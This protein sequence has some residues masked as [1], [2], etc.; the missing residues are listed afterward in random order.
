M[1]CV[2][3]DI[4]KNILIAA[5]VVDI[6]IVQQYYVYITSTMIALTVSLIFIV[7]HTTRFIV[8][9]EK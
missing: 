2:H 7:F 8:E 9:E 4:N 6:L 3:V 1:Q 5:K